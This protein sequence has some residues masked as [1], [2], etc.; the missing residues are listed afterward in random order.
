MLQGGLEAP[1]DGGGGTG[2]RL[3]AGAR[4]DTN[5]AGSGWH[6]VAADW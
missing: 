3:G 2:S 1:V 5:E 6:A 4:G